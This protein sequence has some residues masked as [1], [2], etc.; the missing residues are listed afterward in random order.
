M[1]DS[2][3]TKWTVT[4]KP[5]LSM[6]FFRQEYCNGLLLPTPGDFPDSGIESMSLALAGDSLPLVSPGSPHSAVGVVV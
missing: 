2:F 4:H 1:S 3:A 6:E 5:L